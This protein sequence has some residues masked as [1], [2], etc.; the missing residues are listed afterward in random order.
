MLHTPR[1]TDVRPKFCCGLNIEDVGITFDPLFNSEVVTNASCTP[2]RESESF[3]DLTQIF[4]RISSSVPAARWQFFI[5]QRTHLEFPA[6]TGASSFCGDVTRHRA[7]YTRGVRPRSKQVVMIFDH[8]GHM[9]ESQFEVG[10]AVTR[11]FIQ[12]LSPQDRLA[13]IAVADKA[14]VAPDCQTL[15]YAHD[16]AI[17]GM[18]DFVDNIK[19]KGNLTNHKEALSQAF[20][21]LRNTPSSEDSYSDVLVALISMGKFS[22]LHDKKEILDLISLRRRE[23]KRHR[24][25]INTYM[26][27]DSRRS[28]VFAKDFLEAIAATPIDIQGSRRGASFVVNSTDNLTAT[29][30]RFV[31]AFPPPDIFPPMNYS[32][33]WFDPISRQLL[34]TVALPVKLMGMNRAVPDGVLGF[35][36]PLHYLVEDLQ[37][38][39]QSPEHYAF[40]LNAETGHIMSHPMFV[41]GK[42]V[43]VEG[44]SPLVSSLEPE[45]PPLKLFRYSR[46]DLSNEENSVQYTWKNVEGTPFTVFVANRTTNRPVLALESPISLKEISGRSLVYHR[47]DLISQVSKCTHSNQLASTQAL[48]VFLS[49]V[50]FANPFAHQM[51]DETKESVRSLSHYLFDQ[52]NMMTNPGIV[53]SHIREE[54]RLLAYLTKDWNINTSLDIAIRRYI[55]SAKGVMM[56]WPATIIPQ[57]FDPTM[58]EWYAQAAELT[59]RTVLTGPYLDAAGYGQV[60]TLSRALVRDNSVIAVVAMDL[61]VGYLSKLMGDLFPECD[62]RS[63]GFGDITCFLMDHKGYVV[64]HPSLIDATFPQPPKTPK[65]SLHIAHKEHVV[66]NEILSLKDF[67]KK[68]ACISP[69]DRTVQRTYELR[70]SLANALI[71]V[72]QNELSC[73]KY[74]VSAIA[75]SNLFIGLINKTCHSGQAFTP[76][77]VNDRGCLN[78][79]RMAQDDPECPCQCAWSRTMSGAG[80]CSA[81]AG[82]ISASSTPDRSLD[83]C[84]PSLRSQEVFVPAFFSVAGSPTV[85][86]KCFAETCP[87]KASAS[88]C[89]EASACAWCVSNLA[90]V[91]LDQPYCAAQP[92]CYRGV[93]N[94]ASPYDMISIEE[95]STGYGSNLGFGPVLV[96]VA[97]VI[98]GA[99]VVKFTICSGN[100]AT[101]TSGREQ[102]VPLFIPS[103]Q[104]AEQLCG[105]A[106][107]QSQQSQP[108]VQTSLLLNSFNGNDVTVLS[109]PYRYANNNYRQRPSGAD[110]DLGYSSTITPSSEM[111]PAS[112]ARRA[113]SPESGRASSPSICSSARFALQKK[114]TKGGAGSII[115]TTTA[116]IHSSD[117]ASDFEG[118]KERHEGERL[119]NAVGNGSS[120]KAKEP[121]KDL[122][123]ITVIKEIARDVTELVKM[124]PDNGDCES[125]NIDVGL[126]KQPD[127]LGESDE[128]AKR[129]RQAQRQ[130]QRRDSFTAR[131]KTPDVLSNTGELIEILERAPVAEEIC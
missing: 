77:G 57:R 124:T 6:V 126:T 84:A 121:S 79:R 41:S 36:L 127:Q 108:G 115:I 25:V 81:F 90:H 109:S 53:K 14:T 98:V 10:K 47:L 15:V 55:A 80:Q 5:S 106:G 24:V 102:Q 73:H 48:G 1:R 67:S 12:N 45:L 131:I 107:V 82:D 129:P 58:R 101:Y 59:D 112:T 46:F 51:T 7:A 76:C 88:E 19:Q 86:Q 40:L 39:E 13:V 8:G 26:L 114:K 49:E 63:I 34:V 120:T 4:E 17:R 29:A 52:T 130:K 50:A 28:I 99:V 117:E 44:T 38:P 91:A 104:E 103:E 60:V 105:S 85:L 18:L 64:S 100:A 118:V 65:E 70:M 33:P 83:L 11:F 113:A 66:A 31:E 89:Y 71:N 111:A 116:Q 78:C 42:A 22:H 56:M 125:G 128:H 43:A 72:V 94:G 96:I 62:V 69:S 35:D 54:V 97:F 21:L 74:Y 27:G 87:L 3:Y 16:E 68:S 110:S 32:S 2:S 37:M 23:L 123:D 119:T 30:G 92:H 122:T 20:D 93:V 95:T 9:A 61:N 75:R